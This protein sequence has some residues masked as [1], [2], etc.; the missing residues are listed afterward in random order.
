M[1]LNNNGASWTNKAGWL[2]TDDHCNWDGVS[3]SNDHEVQD[4]TLP[5]NLMSGTFPSDLH[6]LR[7]LQTL[8]VAANSMTG[9]IPSTLCSSNSLYIYGDA[10]NCPNDFNDVTGEYFSG[11]CDNVLYNV[12]IYLNE[13]ATAVLGDSNC[14]NLGGIEETTV[15]VCEYMMN[16]ANHDI[17]NSGYPYDFNGNVWQWLKVG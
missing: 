11:C 15:S 14:A 1:Y 12:D 2:G 7:S 10:L 9:S 13:F 4:I 16:K 8:N 3:C 5:S 6:R 17:F